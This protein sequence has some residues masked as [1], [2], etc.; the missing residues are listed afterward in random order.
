MHDGYEKL[1]G[2]TCQISGKLQDPAPLEY[3]QYLANPGLKN[4]EKLQIVCDLES[5]THQPG[6]QNLK[7]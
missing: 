5:L 6:I 7:H 3:Q 4:A 2:G 1:S